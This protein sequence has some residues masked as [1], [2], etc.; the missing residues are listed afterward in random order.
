MLCTENTKNDFIPILTLIKIK[1]TNFMP[2]PG[3]R[4]KT[5][6]V[7][8]AHVANYIRFKG[9]YLFKAV[10]S[11]FRQTMVSNTHELQEDIL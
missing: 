4:L 6:V 10:F 8:N 9:M 7:L 3:H 5:N 1:C 2:L 11:C